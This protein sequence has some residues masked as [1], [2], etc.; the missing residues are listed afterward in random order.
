MSN[1]IPKCFSKDEFNQNR[2]LSGQFGNVIFSSGKV[3]AIDWTDFH[4]RD[5]GE[6]CTLKDA[7]T[8]RFSG[9]LIT[10]IH[11]EDE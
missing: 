9:E 2:F 4:L 1:L 5:F 6:H 11:S 7:Q 8:I 10:L 3:A